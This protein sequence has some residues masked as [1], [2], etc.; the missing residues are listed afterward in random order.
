MDI[1]DTSLP[2]NKIIPYPN[3]LI[4][5]FREAMQVAGIAYSGEII[6]DGQLHRF[7]IESHKKGSLNGAYKLHIDNYPAGYF[8]DFRSGISQKWRSS[9]NSY[10]SNDIVERIKE[11]KK[12]RAAEMRQKQNEAAKK[13][14]GIW[15][16]SEPIIQ[17][18]EHAYLVKKCIHPH[19]A[20]LYHEALVIPI[21]NESN[22][23]V[24]LQFIDHE[25]KKRF[26]SGGRK[27]GCFYRI[28]EL[29]DTL[30]ICEGFATG[31]SLFKDCGQRVVVAF[32]A[33]NLLPV[34]QS[35]RK[36]NHDNEIII[37][38]DND[39]SGVGQ[40]KAREA[41][42]AIGAKILIPPTAGQDWNDV[43]SGGRHDV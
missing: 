9:G 31:A 27:Q 39:M 14:D 3:D 40:A 43:L 1:T 26:L 33:G 8:Q 34:A 5:Q 22:Q 21:Y 6:P 36:L 37:C 2:C 18:S 30:L 42:L 20:R 24:N 10:V 28:G 4:E 12:R 19:G 23:I 7:Y 13:A 32:D 35:I 25:G 11:T 17:Q 15:L 38:G 29:T 41:A 16:R